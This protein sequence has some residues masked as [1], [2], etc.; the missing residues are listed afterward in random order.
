MELM[1]LTT[2]QNNARGG[3]GRCARTVRFSTSARRRPSALSLCNHAFVA[4]WMRRSAPEQWGRAR[5][6]SRESLKMAIRRDVD[7]ATK[8]S[9]RRISPAHQM[10][11]RIE[12][13]QNSGDCAWW[14]A[15]FPVP[16]W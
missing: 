4:S 1:D 6:E 9:G 3:A 12:S 10:R 7:S 5:E 16:G 2:L 8:S 15:P 13:S 11:E 14:C